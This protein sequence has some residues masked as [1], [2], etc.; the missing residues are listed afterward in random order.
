MPPPF[1]RLLLV[2]TFISN[3]TYGLIDKAGKTLGE[4]RWEVAVLV[5]TA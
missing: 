1:E 5:S 4:G 3:Q 2:K